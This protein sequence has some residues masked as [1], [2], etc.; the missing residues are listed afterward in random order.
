MSSAIRKI[1]R[2]AARLSGDL[3]TRPQPT[4]VNADHYLTLHPTKGWRRVSNKR[5]AAQMAM[6]GIYERAAK[7]GSIRGRRA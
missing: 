6:A 4:I 2:R 7:G 3:G 5:V 1:Q